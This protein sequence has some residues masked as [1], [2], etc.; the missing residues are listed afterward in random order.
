[1]HIPIENDEAARRLVESNFPGVVQAARVE[2]VSLEMC[3]EW[4]RQ[5]PSCSLVIVGAGPPCQGVSRLNFDRRGAKEDPR[6]NLHQYVQPIVKMLKEAFHWCEVKFLQESV[7]SM[8]C[9]D[10]VVYTRAA[11]VIPYQICASLAVVTVSTGSIGLL[12]L[13]RE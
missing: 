8:D 9:E 5:S 13:R 12:T 6:S 2:E 3:K 10:K 1:M 11:D 7:A 4:S